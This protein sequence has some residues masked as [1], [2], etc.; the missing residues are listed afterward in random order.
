MTPR[1]NKSHTARMYDIGV[2]RTRSEP[3]TTPRAQESIVVEWSTTTSRM[4]WR[5]LPSDGREFK[6]FGLNMTD[7][8]LSLLVF[9]LGRDSGLPLFTCRE[10]LLRAS[11]SAVRDAFRGLELL[12]DDSAHEA[13]KV[14]LSNGGITNSGSGDLLLPLVGLRGV[15]FDGGDSSSSSGS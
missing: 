8:I 3:P 6:G 13:S 9:V 12:L 7:L 4:S 10:L 11:I 5:L 15:L 14:S 1:P 2:L